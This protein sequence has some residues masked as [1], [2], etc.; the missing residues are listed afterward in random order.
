[1]KQNISSFS[2]YVLICI[3]SSQYCNV[4]CLLKRSPM[5]KH[6]LSA[7]TMR[8]WSNP[9]SVVHEYDIELQLPP[10]KTCVRHNME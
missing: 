1:M 8:M 5:D 10:Q 6:R 2:W 4:K 3:Y 9:E 7:T